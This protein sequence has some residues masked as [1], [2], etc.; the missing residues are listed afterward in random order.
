MR[1]FHVEK[2]DIVKLKS[3]EGLIGRVVST[4]KAPFGPPCRVW[5]FVDQHDL[6][7]EKSKI[8]KI[9]FPNPDLE[10]LSKREQNENR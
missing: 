7:R 3:E 8:S 4:G 5:W 10:V 6:I 2:G 1:I 9:G